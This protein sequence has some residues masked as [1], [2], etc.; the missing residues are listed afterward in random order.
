[1]HANDRPNLFF[2]N[3]NN[4]LVGEIG[5]LCRYFHIPIERPLS[6]SPFPWKSGNVNAALERP[7]LM[8]PEGI[9][10]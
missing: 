6:L 8:F 10:P 3:M 2:A 1:M 4:I 5:F 9:Y 7:W